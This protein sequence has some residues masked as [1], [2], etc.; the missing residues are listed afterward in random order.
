LAPSYHRLF[1]FFFCVNAYA[2]AAIPGKP[3]PVNAG[4]FEYVVLEPWQT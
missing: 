1:V 4:W 2:S 3:A